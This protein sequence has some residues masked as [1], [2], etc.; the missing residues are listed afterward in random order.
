MIVYLLY[1]YF[2]IR[3]EPPRSVRFSVHH[4][5]FQKQF[6]FRKQQIFY[7]SH[8]LISKSSSDLTI[9]YYESCN[10]HL[11]RLKSIIF[12]IIFLFCFFFSFFFCLNLYSM[13]IFFYFI[14]F[15]I[16]FLFCFF[17]F[18]FFCLNLFSIFFFLFFLH[19]LTRNYFH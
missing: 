17:F 5:Q 7:Y 2:K 3:S 18:S 8:G 16:F 10:K 1:Y 19:I 12:F 4:S 13:H 14:E 11:N 9:I 15:F 6:Q